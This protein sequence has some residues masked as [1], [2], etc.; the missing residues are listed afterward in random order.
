MLRR[1]RAVS[2]PTSPVNYPSGLFVKTESGWFLIRNKTRLRVPSTRILRSWRVKPVQ[3][4][5]AAVKHLPVTG[6]LGFRDGTLIQNYA[7][8]R[9]YIISQNK[10]RLMVSPDVWGWYGLDKS[11]IIVVS[12]SEANL[13]DD[14]EV[15][16]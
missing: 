5:D 16:E 3:T 11:N 13:H 6:K 8:K 2:P 15:L 4:T 1:T 10:K 7:D 9:C 14:G 12:D